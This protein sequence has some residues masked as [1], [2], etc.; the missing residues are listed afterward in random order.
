MSHRFHRHVVE[1][2]SWPWGKCLHCLRQGVEPRAKT[3][4]GVGYGVRR[5]ADGSE[6]PVRLVL[7]QGCEWHAWQWTRGKLAK[8]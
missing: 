2:M 7:M 6:A 3:H 1:P 8:L 4:L 5:F